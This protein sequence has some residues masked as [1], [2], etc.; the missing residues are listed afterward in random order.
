MSYFLV[1]GVFGHGAHSDPPT[2]P[3]Q[4]LSRIVRFPVINV[5]VIW[6]LLDSNY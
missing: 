3:P 2:L 1:V 5:M 4:V 6:V